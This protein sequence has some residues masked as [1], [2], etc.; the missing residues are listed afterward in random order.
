MFFDPISQSSLHVYHSALPLT[1]TNTLL[2]KYFHSELT[3][4]FIVMDG[5]HTDWDGCVRTI[6]VGDLVHSVAFSPIDSVIASAS[7]KHGAQ[8]WNTTT[9]ANIVNLGP[10]Q[11]PSAP[12]CFSPSGARVALAFES[13][14]VAVWDASTAQPLIINE[15]CHHEP[16]TSLNFSP[17]STTLASASR[18]KSIQL[19]EVETGKILHRLQHKDS[20]LCQA[21]SV[22]NKMIVSGCQGG[23][24][25][26]WDVETGQLLRKLRGHSESVN[27][28]AISGDGLFIAS[29]SD[30]KAVRVWDA[31][32]GVC[33]RTY[34]KGHKKGITAVRFTPDNTRVISACPKYVGSWLLSSR[35]S[36]DILWSAN[37]YVKKATSSLPMWYTQAFKFIPSRLVGHM[38][39][40]NRPEASRDFNV[41]FSPDST[42]IAFPLAKGIIYSA[43]LARPIHNNPPSFNSASSNN[44][45]LAISSDGSQVASGNARGSIQLWDPSLALKKWTEFSGYNQMKIQFIRSSPDGNR[46]IGIRLFNLFLLG[47]R[48][49]VIKKLSG[50]EAGNTECVYSANSRNYACWGKVKLNP[51]KDVTA[52]RVYKCSTGDRIFRVVLG[53]IQQVALSTD[54]TLVSCAHDKGVLEVWDVT[55][56]QS[57]HKLPCEAVR[58]IYFAPDNSKIACGTSNGQVHL[59]DLRTGDSLIVIEHGTDKIS[60]IAF[61]PDGN[62][63]AYGYG[64]GSLHV[65]YPLPKGLRHALIPSSKESPDP[66]ARILFSSD[67]ATIN[68]RTFEAQVP[69]SA[70]YA[71]PPLTDLRVQPTAQ[72]IPSPPIRTLSSRQTRPTCATPCSARITKYATAAGYMTATDASYG[73]L[74]LSGL[75]RLPH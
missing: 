62:H 10:P 64:D 59:W 43:S 65:W 28:V 13:G 44:T 69:P 53:K 66:L 54:G 68:C 60:C 8:L 12:I 48:M 38:L 17:N 2:R 42:W 75:P 70:I 39:D 16:V 9:G 20:V 74:P 29:G 4:K 40:A 23:L 51:I 35:K 37:D 3:A 6:D 71:D 41:G 34:T 33:I 25:S 36:F 47:P 18:N 50:L 5:L 22:D 58:C 11:K 55:S 45:A 30:D 52:L 67:G 1:P 63:L 21:F 57:L 26:T 7:A 24:C 72:T 19:W 73:F 14:L 32:I 56:G 46:H 49:E 31:K 61:S 27:S 15:E